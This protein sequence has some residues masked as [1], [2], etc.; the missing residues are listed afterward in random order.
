[1][2][3]LALVAVVSAAAPASADVVV[4]SKY[5][6]STVHFAMARYEDGRMYVRGWYNVQPGRCITIDHGYAAGAYAFYAYSTS[7]STQWP[8]T[9]SGVSHCMKFG[10]RFT[11]RYP[12]NAGEVLCPAGYS[13]RFFKRFKSG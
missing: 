7:S 10:E 2:K 1:M 4:C 8:P 9:K 5:E 6:A 3:R 12:V 13:A 11:V